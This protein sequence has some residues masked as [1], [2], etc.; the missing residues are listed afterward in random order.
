MS[1]CCPSCKTLRNAIIKLMDGSDL[2]SPAWGTR[3][4]ATGMGGENGKSS[5]GS[6]DNTDN[7]DDDEHS[8]VDDAPIEPIDSLEAPTS[9]APT[10]ESAPRLPPTVASRGQRG[11][12][13]ISSTA[14]SSSNNRRR[15]STHNT[16]ISRPRNRQREN[17]PEDTPAGDR[18]GNVMA[19]MMMSQAQDRDERREEREE[20]R[21]EFRLQIEMQRQQMQNQQN[22]MA[23]IMVSMMGR[24]ASGS[25]PND[26]VVN[27]LDTFA[28]NN[29]TEQ[30]NDGEVS[31]SNT[32]E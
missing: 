1:A 5:G 27:M 17:S 18:V 12:T 16:P 4:D 14:T 13:T 29:S 8:Y 21:Q 3:T 30:S 32:Q 22:M 7:Q 28:G 31:N 9:D 26:G 24:N 15:T 11:S 23:M 10:G 25:V 2:N 20:R 6:D 19:M